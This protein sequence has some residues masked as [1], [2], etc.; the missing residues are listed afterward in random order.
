[1]DHC[2]KICLGCCVVVC[3]A[4]PVEKSIDQKGALVDFKRKRNCYLR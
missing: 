2:V 4:V 3:N 1:M